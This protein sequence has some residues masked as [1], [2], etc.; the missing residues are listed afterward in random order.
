MA[1]SWVQ[2]RT[3]IWINYF[4][5][6]VLFFNPKGIRSNAANV[7]ELLLNWLHSN[8]IGNKN[9]FI[10]F[11]QIFLKVGE[12]FFMKCFW[13]LLFYQSYSFNHDESRIYM[14]IYSCR[15]AKN[16]EN[17]LPSLCNILLY[18]GILS[19]TPSKDKRD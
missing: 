5:L 8:C 1:K 19:G 11:V 2:I 15:I 4:L 10:T 12:N 7:L 3:W 18:F 14:Y 17:F 16:V 6:L 13:V 9:L